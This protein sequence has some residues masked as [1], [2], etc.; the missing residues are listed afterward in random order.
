[1]MVA[2]DVTVIILLCVT[3]LYCTKLYKKIDHLRK[4]KQEFIILIKHFNDSI[5]KAEKSVS[6]LKKL[7]SLTDQDF[8]TKVNEAKIVIDNL[9]YMMDKANTL[10]QKM[11]SEHKAVLKQSLRNNA[12]PFPK[13]EP[14]ITPTATQNKK[15]TKQQDKTHILHSLMERIAQHREEKDETVKG[16]LKKEI[17]DTL[18]PMKHNETV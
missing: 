10:S 6:D 11:Q 7:S 12:R 3:I 8:S 16:E 2:L 18:K 17:I 15:P 9:E 13:T 4:G 5:I 1:M 14:K